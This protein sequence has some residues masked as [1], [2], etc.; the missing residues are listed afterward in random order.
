MHSKYL[1]LKES[2]RLLKLH[3][4]FKL[5]RQVCLAPSR[6]EYARGILKS[7]SQRPGESVATFAQRIIWLMRWSRELRDNLDDFQHAVHQHSFW[8]VIIAGTQDKELKAAVRVW[9]KEQLSIL[10][11]L[12]KLTVWE[13][14]GTTQMAANRKL[15]TV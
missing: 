3:Q 8:R 5:I 9:G 13:E 4:F 10:R 12:A 2:W 14:L 6:A 15:V 7:T 11:C 1:M